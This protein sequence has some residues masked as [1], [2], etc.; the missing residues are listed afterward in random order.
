MPWDTGICMNRTINSLRPELFITVET[1]LWPVLFQ[2][3][4]AA[5]STLILLNGR[6]SNTSFKGYKRIRPF[7]KRVLSNIDYFYMQGETD[8]QRIIALGADREKVKV[9]GNFKFDIEINRSEQ[10]KWTEHLKEKTLLAG[11]THKGEEEIILNAYE[12]IKR[13]FNDLGL[14]LAPRHPERFNEVEKILRDRRLDYIR[15]TKLEVEHGLKNKK[16]DIILLD[17]IGELSPLFSMAT[18]TFIGGSLFP[19]GGHNILE[20]AYWSK[21]IIF[22]P[23][24]DNFP[25]AK[26]FLNDSAALMVRGHEDIA[27]KVRALIKDHEKARRMG[28]RARAIIERNKGATEK[29]LELIRSIIGST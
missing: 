1:E 22:G 21:P 3:L 20:P 18:I 27:E 25:F 16:Y 24:M 17:T 15:R 13:E 10:P 8:A 5:G 9:M 29:A 28:E 26:E 23:Y 14:L 6:V 4:K 19:Y 11:S 2:G 12:I 7:M